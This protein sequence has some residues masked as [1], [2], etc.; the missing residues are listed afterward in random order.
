[1]EHMFCLCADKNLLSVN[2][3][4]LL[5]SGSANVYYVRFKFS[6][7]WEGLNKTVAFRAGE[8][9]VSTLLDDNGVCVVPWEPLMIPGLRLEVG[10]YGTRDGEIILPTLWASLGIIR[11]GVGSGTIPVPTPGIYDQLLKRLE[12]KGDGLSYEAG[13]LR[14]TAGAREL[15]AVG[16]DEIIAE[17]LTPVREQVDALGAEAAAAQGGINALGAEVAAAQEGINALGAEVAALQA[18]VPQQIEEAMGQAI[19]EAY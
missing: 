15:S 9:C 10:V 8:V 16:L 18:S 13:T 3:R 11:Q 6:A 14:L 4:E 5:T 1:M 19:K 7:D 12:E 17:K 2:R